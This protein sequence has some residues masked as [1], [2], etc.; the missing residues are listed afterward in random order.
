MKRMINANTNV[1]DVKAYVIE[2]LN[3][4]EDVNLIFNVG[5]RFPNLTIHDFTSIVSELSW[6]GYKIPGVEY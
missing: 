6:E 3:S 2:L 1:E 4:G 5:G